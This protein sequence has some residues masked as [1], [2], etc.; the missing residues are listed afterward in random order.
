MPQED[1]RGEIS[2]ETFDRNDETFARL[3]G[4]DVPWLFSEEAGPDYDKMAKQARANSSWY[5]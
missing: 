5:S 2:Q 1:Y 4:R 3:M